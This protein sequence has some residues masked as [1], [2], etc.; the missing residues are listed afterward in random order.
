MVRV[1]RLAGYITVARW[2]PLREFGLILGMALPGFVACAAVFLAIDPIASN[3]WRPLPDQAA[4]SLAAVAIVAYFLAGLFVGTASNDPDVAWGGCGIAF[5][6]ST[7]IL[8]PVWVGLGHVAAQQEPGFAAVLWGQPIIA[9]TT[10]MFG[11]G[12]A[13]VAR[14]LMRQSSRH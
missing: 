14:R 8:L 7:G 5:L 4:L 2:D 12:T 10:Y 6:F 3:R 1:I 9:V 13:R 11:M